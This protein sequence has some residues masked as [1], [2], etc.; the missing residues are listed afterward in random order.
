MKA[1]N[2]AKNKSYAVFKICGNNL[3]L[4]RMPS[5]QQTLTIPA[6]STIITITKLD[7]VKTGHTLMMVQ[8]D[9]DIPFNTHV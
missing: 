2:H 7:Y 4:Q 8:L 9:Q 3:W 5:Q 6:V 1:Y